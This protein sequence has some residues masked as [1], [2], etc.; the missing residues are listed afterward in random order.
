MLRL[1]ST[2]GREVESQA[3]LGQGRQPHGHELHQQKTGKT[4]ENGVLETQ[5]FDNFGPKK[6]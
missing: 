1:G 3:H 5:H 2:R 4:Q 6:V